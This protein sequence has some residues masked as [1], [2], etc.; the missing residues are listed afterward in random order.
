MKKKSPLKFGDVLIIDEAGQVGLNHALALFSH[1]KSIG[2]KVIMVGED[3]QLQPIESGSIL[4]KLSGTHSMKYKSELSML[5]EV[6][7]G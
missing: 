5:G 2:F 6:K 7:V 3:K 1:A 4:T